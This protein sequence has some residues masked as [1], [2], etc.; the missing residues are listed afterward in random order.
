MKKVFAAVAAI[1]SGA[2]PLVSCALSYTCSAHA[3]R[4]GN[5]DYGREER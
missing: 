4:L 1:I 5:L 3:E 2:S